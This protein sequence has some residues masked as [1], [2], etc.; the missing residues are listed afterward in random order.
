MFS[1][2]LNETNK[3][4]WDSQLQVIVLCRAD[5]LF[6]LQIHPNVSFRPQQNF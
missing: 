4:G 2:L 5:K 1:N 3:A 6:S